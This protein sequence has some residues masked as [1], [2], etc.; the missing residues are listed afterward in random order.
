MIY[1]S[2][3]LF[4]C[5]PEFRLYTKKLYSSLSNALIVSVWM[6]LSATGDVNDEASDEGDEVEEDEEELGIKG[7]GER[8][9]ISQ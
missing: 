3:W 9:I 6:G 4:S 7:G 8:V 1:I 2:S 5:S